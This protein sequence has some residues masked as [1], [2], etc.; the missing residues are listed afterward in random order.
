MRLGVTAADCNGSHLSPP[1]VGPQTVPGRDVTAESAAE[2]LS[3][4][5]MRGALLTKYICLI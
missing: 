2:A 1:Q 5:Q 4:I 3:P